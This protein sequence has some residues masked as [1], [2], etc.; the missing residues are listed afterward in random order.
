LRSD[1]DGSAGRF[2]VKSRDTV[3]PLRRK[4]VC[5]ERR[6]VGDGMDE[7][8]L[9]KARFVR[10]APQRTVRRQCLSLGLSLAFLTTFACACDR[11]DSGG[12]RRAEC[13]RFCESLE[14]CDDVTDLLDC[15]DQ[16]EADDVR[17]DRYYAARADCA[18]KLSCSRWV[19]EVNGRGEDVCNADCNLID[20]VDDSL[21]QLKLSEDEENV[22]MALGTKINACK[23]SLDAREV[24]AECEAVIPVLSA[25]YLEDSERCGEQE[26]GLIAGCFDK[27]SDRHQTDL[28][29]FSGPL[30]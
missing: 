21:G 24:K 1:G 7:K 18:E 3:R 8:T 11:A 26:C 9:L 2:A 30:N 27:L 19:H 13:A 29:L 4:L 10:P 6:V 17:S 23:S 22:C 15:R 5:F 16:C 20:C 25:A 12:V 28:K 14:K